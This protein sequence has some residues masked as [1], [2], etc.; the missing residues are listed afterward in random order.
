MGDIVNTKKKNRPINLDLST[1]HFPMT[2]IA[3]ILHRITG[4][5]LFAAVA[6][7]LWLLNLS[8]SSP[9]GF[10][11]ASLLLDSFLVKFILWGILTALFY[12]LVLGIRHLCM[13]YGWFEEL[14]SGLK[15][16]KVSFVIVAILSLFSG[17]IVW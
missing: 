1:L 11:E 5:I 8:L 13:D 16:A 14:E 6:I 10:F 17:A 15:S 4:V 9:D 3:S 7:L 12:H 2:A